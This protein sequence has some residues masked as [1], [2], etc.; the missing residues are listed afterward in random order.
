MSEQEMSE[1]E[2]F[3]MWIGILDEEVIQG[4]FGYERGEFTVYP[5]HWLPLYR[6]GLS[7]LQAWQRAM[8]AHAH[9]RAEEDKR[10]IENYERIKSEDAATNLKISMGTLGAPK[11]QIKA[12]AND[13]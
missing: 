11:E 9:W 6:E 2:E 13:H 10:K 1:S 8:E 4:E 5:D 3:E 12:D 7:P